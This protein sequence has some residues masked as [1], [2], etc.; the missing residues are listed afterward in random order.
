MASDLMETD[1]EINYYIVKENI[2]RNMYEVV[3]RY[4]SDLE[5][6]LQHLRL[7]GSTERN[8][9]GRLERDTSTP[10][11]LSYIG[12]A[13]IPVANMKALHPFSLQES[14]PIKS[15]FRS[16][17]I[18]KALECCYWSNEDKLNHM[19]QVA[20]KEHQI[21]MSARKI[22]STTESQSNI[23]YDREAF[24][25]FSK[26]FARSLG[27]QEDNNADHEH[28][29]KRRRSSLLNGLTGELQNKVCLEASDSSSSA[30]GKISAEQ[31][32]NSRAKN[33][34]HSTKHT[35][36]SIVNQEEANTFSPSKVFIEN[37]DEIGKNQDGKGNG[38]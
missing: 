13:I 31:F 21:I 2:E 6:A 1:Q 20:E 26:Q 32:L 18:S 3:G 11:R 36:S 28:Q 37:M 16:D 4:N 27:Q 33:E 7:F 14:T 30:G 9:R 29:P 15:H 5:Q 38:S 12:R 10:E 25:N 22:S 24:Y 17:P 8:G 19:M 34:K 35:T 23:V